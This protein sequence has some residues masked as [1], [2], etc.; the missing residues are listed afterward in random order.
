[1][2]GLSQIERSQKVKT[3]KYP[4]VLEDNPQLLLRQMLRMASFI[5]LLTDDVATIKGE[6][7]FEDLFSNALDGDDLLHAYTSQEWDGNMEPS[8]ALIISFLENLAHTSSLFNE[9][10]KDLPAHY[11]ENIVGV[12]RTPL[13]PDQ[14]W[15]SFKKGD[16]DIL[17]I[18]KGTKYKVKRNDQFFFYRS[19]EDVELSSATV[20]KLFILNDKRVKSTNKL[21][22]PGHH[23]SVEQL[24]MRDNCVVGCL[25][26]E[27]QVGIRISSSALFLSEGIRKINL[28]LHP[29]DFH[30]SNYRIDEQVDVSESFLLNIST[31]SGWEEISRPRIRYKK[32]LI[33]ITFTVNESFQPIIAC[34]NELHGYSSHYPILNVFVNLDSSLYNSLAP[35]KMRVSKVSIDVSVKDHGDVQVYNELGAIDTSKPFSPFGTS[36]EQGSWFIIGHY[37]SNLKKTKELS[38]NLQWEQLLS[39]SSSLKE[40][41]SEYNQK[42]EDSSFQVD[43][44]YLLDFEWKSP[45]SKRRF[46]LFQY[47]SEKAKLLKSSRIGSFDL[48]KVRATDLPED[49]FKYSMQS[50]EGFIQIVLTNPSM[51][52][53][54]Q[55]YRKIFT[56][57][58]LRNAKKKKFPTIPPPVQ[59]VLSR[60]S[61][62]YKAS[63]F[64]EYGVVSDT[65]PYSFFSPI[66][67][68]DD[69]ISIKSCYADDV[70]LI[71]NLE[72]RNVIFALA[73]A[74]ANTCVS[75]FID[76]LPFETEDLEDK[77]VYEQ[78]DE[79]G[80]ITAYLG[81]PLRWEKAE[82]S[83]IKKDETVGL[84]INGVLIIQLPEKIPSYLYDQD[85]LLWIRINYENK[86]NL[87]FPEI[88]SIHTNVS[89]L[90]LITPESTKGMVLN[91]TDG[92]VEEETVVPGV[93]GIDRI[94]PFYNGRYAEN[95]DELFLRVSEYTK[96]KGRAVTK[97][98]Y[99][100]LIL[101]R[102]PEIEKVKCIVKNEGEIVIYLVIIPR[103]CVKSRYPLASPFE[104]FQVERYIKP[105]ISSYVH[106]LRV[107]N[108]TYEELIIKCGIE[109]KGYF[110]ARNRKK[111]LDKIN[112]R[113][114]PWI[115]SSALPDFDYVL[116]LK[117]LYDDLI[118]D[119]GQLISIKDFIALR[120]EKQNS[121]L[122]VREF[123]YLTKGVFHA[124]YKISTSE[125][126]GV[127]IP[128]DNPIFYWDKV[129]PDQFGIAEMNI[130]NNFIIS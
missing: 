120:V 122:Y 51:G 118:R 126:H 92:V 116:D 109:V 96:H 15:V 68:L 26:I 7:Y 4:K 40:H 97:A 125:E 94:T 63:D 54:D 56:E 50:R 85:G 103:V 91:A 6:F 25:P 58:L 32:G 13:K 123:P 36:A 74:K 124:D 46:G 99:K 98:D 28:V 79:I 45:R 49:E 70:G 102:F 78:R 37:E 55:V 30:W 22:A 44:K 121:G 5:R 59:P 129:V 29:K 8:R 88:Q 61:I 21:Q 110:S 57:Q 107:I 33:E 48:E 27:S 113:I 12:Q 83:I 87:D 39:E 52:F 60:I 11:L 80:K 100:Q 127:F 66:V 10:W 69:Y 128:S 84:W 34:S 38:V 9:R 2:S 42:I 3:N 72:G 112:D 130:S 14:V 101:Q 19:V 64:I 82:Q 17:F 65:D 93:V 41:Y 119:F 67:P 35:Q 16:E 47:D 108:P 75:L 114:A 43:V 1:M 53:G 77:S 31:T 71:P 104:L 20:N 105:L 76:F 24:T 111:L 90:E 86:N 81:N 23:Y 18:P 95:V 73:N 62:D 115:S 89:K 106:N 117:Q